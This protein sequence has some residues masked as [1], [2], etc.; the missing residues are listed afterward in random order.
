MPADWFA[1]Y[2]KHQ[3]EKS[4]ASLL[5]RKGIRQFLPLY[6]EVHRWKDRK[7]K[8][9]LP[10]FPCYLF[11]LTDLSRKLEVLQTAGVRWFVENAGRACPVPEAEIEAL[12]KVCASGIRVEPHP[13]LKQG[14]TVRL[15]EG[16][17]AGLQGI[18][19]QLKNEHRIVLSVELLK[20][21]VAVEVDILSVERIARP[22][23]PLSGQAASEDRN[24]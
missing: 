9:V 14:D 13:F 5:E 20:R 3:H 6:R 17:L 21:S 18:L 11:V 7:Q 10:L 16:P 24:T 22:K 1:V 4:A 2:T 8:V 23:N 15:N 12:Q 19:T